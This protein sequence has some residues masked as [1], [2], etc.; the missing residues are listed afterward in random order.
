MTTLETQVKNSSTRAIDPVCHMTVEPGKTKLV[1]VYNGHSYW[2]CAEGCRRA[3]EDAPEKYLNP[4]KKRGW[5][6]RWLDRMAKSNKE[7]FGGSGAKCH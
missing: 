3:F 4:Q 7:V 6:G 2:F 5:F 1:S